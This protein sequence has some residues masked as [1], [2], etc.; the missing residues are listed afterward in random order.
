MKKK[1][2]ASKVAQLRSV[3]EVDA[4]GRFPFFHCASVGIPKTF[5]VFFFFLSTALTV[6]R[7]LKNKPLKCRGLCLQTHRCLFGGFICFVAVL[8]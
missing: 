4:K 3:S 7:R 2:P 8:G 1:K 5:A 6:R